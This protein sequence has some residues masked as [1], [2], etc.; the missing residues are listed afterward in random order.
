MNSF[1]KRKSGKLYQFIDYWIKVYILEPLV[2][3]TEIAEGLWV[4]VKEVRRK[5][6]K[7]EVMEKR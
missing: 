7:T 4:V 5:L 1:L 6:Q 2:R 3:T